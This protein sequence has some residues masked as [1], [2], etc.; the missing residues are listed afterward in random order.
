ML[1]QRA[2]EYDHNTRVRLL[3]AAL[4]PATAYL[5]AQRL[6]EVI[7]RALLQALEE[8]DVIA[9]PTTPGPAPKIADGP[10]IHGREDARSRMLGAR[11]FTGAFNLAGLPALSLPCGFTAGDAANPP[12]PLSLQLAGRPLEDALLLRVG[13]AYQ[14][15][16]DW[17][18]RRPPL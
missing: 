18:T 1:Q 14:Q 2:R 17:H 5:K 6:R 3:T 13:H 10:G 8:V 4:T 15:A 9:L 7:R 16:T 11:N 12:M